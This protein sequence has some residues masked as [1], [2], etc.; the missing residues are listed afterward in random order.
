MTFCE[1]CGEKI[2]YL[3]F[4]CKYCG[5]TYC[6]KHRLPENHDCSFE[7][8]H[9]PVVPTTTR[10][11]RPR[12]QDATSERDYEY[13]MEKQRRR[14]LKQ[15][16]RQMKRAARGMD[17]SLP[18][19]GQAKG[20]NIIIIMIVIFSI[21]TTILAIFGLSHLIAFSLWGVLNLF[22][23]TIITA[24]FISYSA[25]LFGLFFLLILIMFLYNIAK[26]IE[27]RFGTKFLIGL[28]I[29]CA[30]FTALFYILIR[31]LLGPIYPI[32]I[33]IIPVGLATGAII[34]LISF[35]VYFNPNRE[36]MMFCYFVPLKM[37]GKTL[38]IVLILFRLIPKLLF[39]YFYGPIQYCYY[40]PDLGG[41]IGAYIV[42]RSKYKSR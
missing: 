39:G 25:S 20:T 28:Y 13:K 6:K 9:V 38:L 15:R 27:I 8:K 17:S 23:W 32:G 40:F 21:T 14:Y 10:D 2:G 19:T 7:L 11:A 12:Y 35:I 29:F 37:K 33:I 42:F 41:M 34:G 3:P 18:G 36:M 24:L 26:N 16:E 31:L 4:K 30:A 1:H 5:G 22:L